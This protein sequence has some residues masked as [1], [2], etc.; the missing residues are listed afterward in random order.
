[1]ESTGK[2]ALGALFMAA[3]LLAGCGGGDSSAPVPP[4]PPAPPSSPVPA[5][6]PPASAPVPAPP[7][8]G[9]SLPR[10]TG[11]ATIGAT[12]VNLP[13]AYPAFAGHYVGRYGALV[14]DIWAVTS[15]PSAG[16]I[17]VVGNVLDGGVPG[18]QGIDPATLAVKWS[19][20]TPSTGGVVAVS[21]DGSKA[22][23]G[24]C[25]QRSV[26]QVDL[27]THAVDVVFPIGAPNQEICAGD[28]AVRP[29]HP[30]TIAVTQIATGTLAPQSF[31][32]AMFTNG[33]ALPSVVNNLTSMFYMSNGVVYSSSAV[34]KFLGPDTLLGYTD[35][36]TNT[37]VE[38]YAVDASGLSLAALQGA[39]PWSENIT[40]KN[41]R[42]YFGFGV[43]VDAADLGNVRRFPQ[44]QSTDP[45]YYAALP[46]PGRAEL[47]CIGSVPQT[48]R[49][50]LQDVELV[51]SSWSEDGER[52]TRRSRLNLRD[53]I[54]I[55]GFATAEVS[56]LKS[57]FTPDGRLLLHIWDYQS[58]RLLLVVVPPDELAAVAA[59]PVTYGHLAQ[60]GAVLD[61]VDVPA[62]ATAFD[63]VAGRLY[64]IVPGSYGPQGASIVA[65]D[66]ASR[67]VLGFV[68]VP[69]EPL[70]LSL[71]SDGLSAYVTL[72]NG[73]QQVNLATLTA[74]WFWRQ[75]DCTISAV[76]PRPGYPSQVL[77]ATGVEMHLLDA[78]SEIARIAPMPIGLCGSA[79]PV[80]F[81][82]SNQLAVLMT[83]MARVDMYS[84]Q[85][86]AI[87]QVP[88]PVGAVAGGGGGYFRA[89]ASGYAFND[90]G[91]VADARTLTIVPQA[92]THLSYVNDFS[93]N[94][95]ADFTNLG[96]GG[97]CGCG[98]L[99]AF[100][101]LTADRFLAVRQQLAGVALFDVFT[102][103]AH[104][105]RLFVTDAVIG[106]SQLEPSVLDARTV[107]FGQA[108]RPLGQGAIYWMQLPF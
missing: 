87:V 85:S 90:G 102:D 39:E 106:T 28:I 77:I 9:P 45:D 4:T 80:L 93:A 107:A 51:L 69:G 1:M 6:P 101:P 99:T 81:S 47:V 89:T 11:D 104:T 61:W 100:T 31:G 56:I 7:A 27:A 91:D 79:G 62:T 35:Y 50:G 13:S 58:S 41:G 17:V 55:P 108:S 49:L 12:I 42:L 59:P 54:T 72:D 98:P 24:L 5:P 37:Q 36:T 75:S 38:R 15:N 65:L 105:G 10:I 46:D 26:A 63:P 64:G 43:A 8:S 3:A 84:L 88:T 25:G 52:L 18:M 22:F 71:S 73:V 86:G 96:L 94:Y 14:N 23:V 67:Q 40:L 33:V 60:D 57:M 82:D 74:G 53:V 32:T 48:Q 68:P 97:S 16:E 21:D 83:D 103:T 34:I 76:A 19:V 2:G 44:C 30:T 92:P 29:G 20:A 66:A 70:A 95:E 78:G